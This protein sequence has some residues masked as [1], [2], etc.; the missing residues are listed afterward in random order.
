M[1]ENCPGGGP[2][3]PTW[4][5]FPRSCFSKPAWPP[6]SPTSRGLSEED[7]LT[8]WSGLG[9][10]SR[11][12]NMHRAAKLI[13]ALGSFPDD[14]DSLRQLPGVGQYTAA[15]V[16]SIAFGLPHAV[17][18]GNV[19][20]VLSRLAC[21]ND[22][23]ETMAEALLDRRHP[24][25]YNQALMELGATVCLPGEPQCESCPVAAHCAAKRQGRQKEFPVRKQRPAAI[26]VA[27][28]LLRVERKDRLL[29]R[30]REGFWELPEAGQLPGAVA[31]GKLFEFRHSV[32]N[33]S[34]TFTLFSATV[35]RVPPGFE[36]FPLV[37]LD[38]IPLSTVARKALR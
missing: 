17:V 27:R 24:G 1:P 4:S 37:E 31:V 18:D 38:R 15:A 26:Q 35:R 5:G 10:Y 25:N 21:R 20:R 12:R 36:W 29:L 22:G 11:A 9:Y 32:T 3:N 19:R 2:A 34:Y 30:K 6:W 8:A 33:H 13:A 16:A 23:L 28:Q 14:Y 7:L